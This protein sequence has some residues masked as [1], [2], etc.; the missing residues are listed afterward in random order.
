MKG[1]PQASTWGRLADLLKLRTMDLRPGYVRMRMPW[2]RAASQMAGLLHGGALVTLADT[3]AAVGTLHLLPRGFSTVTSELKVNFISNIR[4]GVAVAEAKLL[5]R[6][7][8]TFVWEVK[9]KDQASRRLL[10]AASGTFFVFSNGQKEKR[11]QKRS[12][13]PQR[14][15][16]RLGFFQKKRDHRSGSERRARSRS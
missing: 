8:L 11:E 2:S 4:Q 15:G 6:G 16:K 1:R 14:P 3:C 13:S 5:H 10:A 12:R 7:R 9:I